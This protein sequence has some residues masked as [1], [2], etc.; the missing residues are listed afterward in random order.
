MI[1]TKMTNI[2]PDEAFGFGSFS[3][4]SNAIFLLVEFVVKSMSSEI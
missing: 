1:A 4:D 2:A 3:G